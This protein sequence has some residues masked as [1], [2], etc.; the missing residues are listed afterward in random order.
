MVARRR[1]R[2]TA[3]IHPAGSATRSLQISSPSP[4]APVY[5]LRSRYA[6]TGIRKARLRSSRLRWRPCGQ[7]KGSSAWHGHRCCAHV[8]QVRC[9]PPDPADLPCISAESRAGGDL[10]STHGQML[11]L[12][13]AHIRQDHRPPAAPKI[14]L[15]RLTNPRIPPH[16]RDQTAVQ[17]PSTTGARPVTVLGA[18][19]ARNISAHPA[20]AT[21]LEFL[22]RRHVRARGGLRTRGPW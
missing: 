17:P 19:D 12:R 9:R 22:S 6:R 5:E 10:P 21:V 13:G 11:R 15:G 16:G 7:T 2:R 14:Q 4:L 20:S 3:V 1:P 18:S 8:P